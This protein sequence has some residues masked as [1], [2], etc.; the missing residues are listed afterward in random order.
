MNTIPSVD[1][2]GVSGYKT[3]TVDKTVQSQSFFFLICNAHGCVFTFPI[4]NQNTTF[5]IFNFFFL[6][7]FRE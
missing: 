5:L 6:N 2:K 4:F 7:F 1:Q 3:N